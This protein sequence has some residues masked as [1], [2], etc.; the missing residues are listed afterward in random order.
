MIQ[1]SRYRVWGAANRARRFSRLMIFGVELLVLSRLFSRRR[2]LAP[3]EI[4]S[5]LLKTKSIRYF[6]PELFVS[7]TDHRFDC[8]SEGFSSVNAS[9]FLNLHNPDDLSPARYAHPA[10]SFRAI[11]LWDSAFIAQVWKWWDPEV[12]WD[13]LRSV[14]ELRDGSRLQ[15]FVAEFSRSKFTQPPLLAWSL[16]RLG[17]AAGPGR[18]HDWAKAA[19]EPLRAYHYWLFAHRQLPNG[20]FAWAHPYESGVENAPRFSSRDERR[21]DD[22]ST[23]AAPDFCTYMVL[24]C[25]ALASLARGVGK[26]KQ[27]AVHEAEAAQLR[28][29]I[30]EYLWDEEAGLYFDRDTGNGEFVRSR[31]IASLMPLWAGVPDASQARRLLKHIL[32]PTAFNTV[33][34]LPSVAL[35]DESFERDMWRGPVWVNTAF[36]VIAGL[37]RYEFHDAAAD[38]AFRLCDGVYRTFQ[39]TGRFHEFYDPSRYGIGRLHRKRGNRWK[40]IT[41]GSGPVIDFVGWSGLVNTLV[42]DVLFGLRRTPEGLSMQPRFPAR[43]EGLS[44]SLNLPVDDLTIDLEVAPE[45]K[46]H[47]TTRGREGLSRFE[48]ASGETVLLPSGSGGQAE[49]RP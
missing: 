29:A 20:L 49:L 4:T 26:E 39:H 1:E 41:L 10:P 3:P 16:E 32:E 19:Y 6:P 12:A 40:R 38:L 42:M 25:E 31:T 22:T 28:A 15:H 33:I 30:N 37:R 45:G 17:R 8:W 36:A 24:Q 9:L 14:I 13:V 23:L 5:A 7:G 44:F 27:A 34:P 21:L 46:V 18:F 48:A 2:P 43:A 35:D 11:Y 47:G